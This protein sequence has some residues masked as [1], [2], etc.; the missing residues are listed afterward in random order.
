MTSSSSALS[1]SFFDLESFAAWSRA[2]Y[3]MM[4]L[5]AHTRTM[6]ESTI[7]EP[8]DLLSGVVR[9]AF[10]EP[11]TDRFESVFGRGNRFV[12]S[13]LADHYGFDPDGIVCTAGAS[14]AVS[15]VLHALVEPGDRVLVE[16]PRFDV[17]D[18][19]ARECG[20]EVDFLDRAETGMDV[21][22][23]RLAAAL[24]P[25]TRLVLISNLHN[26]SGALL[27]RERLR[28]IADIA[29]RRGVL[30]LVDEVY[31]GFAE[32]AGEPAAAR[33]APNLISVNSL[34]KVFGL[35]AL[36]CGWILCEPDL[37][38][39]IA[40]RNAN[41]E[42][43]V[44]KLTHALAALV[45]EDPEPFR[46]HWRA[47]LDRTRPVME[48]HYDAMRRDGLIAGELPKYGCICFPEIVDAPDTRRLARELWVRNGLLLAPGEFFGR[49]GHVRL[50]FGLEPAALDDGLGRLHQ[51]LFER[52]AGP[53]RTAP[54]H[55]KAT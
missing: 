31:G 8:T 48:R 36:R 52:R 34:T 17:L 38:R 42:F 26:P 55:A 1:D 30:V 27:S 35:F 9:N 32:A 46:A 51:A 54:L 23:E 37:A 44:S 43:G 50:G 15:M 3:R 39:T 11:V 28:E 2:L 19:L 25:Q 21:D 7:S 45:L 53:S 12:I 5:P 47:I 40:R 10:G 22:P 16:T 49:A 20:A 14:T 4:P 6:F 41:R 13:A 29:A 24:T 33:L 18:S